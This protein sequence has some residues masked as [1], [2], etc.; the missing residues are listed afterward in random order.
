MWRS[1]LLLLC[2][3]LY[4]KGNL[5]FLTPFPIEKTFACM[6]SVWWWEMPQIWSKKKQKNELLLILILP[7]EMHWKSKQMKSMDFFFLWVS[8]DLYITFMNNDRLKLISET[9]NKALLHLLT[10]PLHQG[11]CSES[12]NMF[13]LTAKSMMLSSKCMSSKYMRLSNK[14][15]LKD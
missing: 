8:W 11:H 13:S 3:Y 7:I 6:R 4:F 2:W 15:L 10:V 1:D 12:G 14:C 5:Y 9:Y